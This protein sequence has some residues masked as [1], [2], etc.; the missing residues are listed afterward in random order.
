MDDQELNQHMKE[1][2]NTMNDGVL[3]ISTGG[4]ILMANRAMEQISGYSREEMQGQPCSI[5]HC[6]VCEKNH[7]KGEGHWC[8]LFDVGSSHRKTCSVVRK[9]GSY[10]NVLKN[11]SILKE[12]DGTILGA[13][14]TFTDISD[15]EERDEKIE[16][17]SKLLHGNTDFQGMVGR[18]EIMQRVFEVVRKA[19]TSDA[20]VIVFGETGTG[21]ELVAHAIHKL[22]PRRDKPYI[23][24]NCAAL[25]ENLLESEMF[26]HVKGAFTG[27]HMNRK[28][29]FEAANGGDI[30]LDEIGDLP[31]SIQ[32]KLLR[33]LE[34]KQFER[35][36]DYQPIKTDVRI[37]TATNRDL[38]QLIAQRKFREDFFF[39][40]NV[41]PI[42][43]PPLRDR[44]DDIPLLAEHF[45]RKLQASSGKEIIGMAPETMDF[46]M[47][48]RWPGNI[49]ELRGALEYAFVV[50]E[51]GRIL[52]KHLPAR[53]INQG[54][55]HE[56]PVS[57]P[58]TEKEALIDALIRSGGNQTRAAGMLGVN[59]VTV[60][61]RL[62]KYGI[63]PGNPVPH[64]NPFAEDGGANSG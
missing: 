5:F 4:E 55:R 6:A 33:I 51:S 60:W 50:A 31:L 52:P 17:L 32:I 47:N 43:L 21:K 59:R 24:L 57:A 27:A 37:I 49:R 20:P 10:L 36:G 42:H 45:V 63:D 25:N 34:T 18:S 7:T 8:D 39:R 3:V 48:Y 29:R 62:K 23:Q 64:S 12:A 28:G 22:G 44:T 9:D 26:G 58:L 15:I 2:I 38:E 1:I 46:F 19:A 41:I 53:M 56:I 30:F 11:A 16:Q 35:V 40:I 13:V 14:E 61:H 54:I